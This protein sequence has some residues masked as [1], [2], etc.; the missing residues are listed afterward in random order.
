MK[1]KSVVNNKNKNFAMQMNKIKTT[2]KFNSQ[3]VHQSTLKLC[4]C[5]LL[6]KRKSMIQ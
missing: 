2:Q 1:M 4:M 6:I 5:N 3:S